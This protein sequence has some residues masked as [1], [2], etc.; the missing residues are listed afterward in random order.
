MQDAVAADFISRVLKR[1]GTAPGNNVPKRGTSNEEA[2]AAY[3]QGMYLLDRTQEDPQ[4]AQA[5]IAAFDRAIAL[6]R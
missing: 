5:A 4:S 2:Y 1:F 6:A 3:L